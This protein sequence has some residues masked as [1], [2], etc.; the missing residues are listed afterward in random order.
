M[1]ATIK[2][3]AVKTGLGVGTISKYLNGGSVKEKNRIIIES[4]IKELNYTVNEFARGLKTNKTRT[5]GILVPEFENLF[6]MSIVSVIEE[7]LQKEGYGILA[8]D[9][10]NDVNLEEQA[11]E[12]LLKKHVSGIINIPV[13]TSGK[14]L[15]AAQEQ[16]IPFVIIDR[17]LRGIDCNTVIIDNVK[18]SYDVTELL[19]NSGHKKIGILCGPKSVFT[20]QRR[21][22]GYRRALMKHSI[23]PDKKLI[24][25]GN[26]KIEGGYQAAKRL[27]TANE[28]MTAL[29]V[30]D[31]ENTL[32]AM[33]ALNECGIKVPDDLSVV[34]FDNLDLTKVLRPRL[35][36]VSQPIE[37]IG[38]YA[39][40][41]FLEGVT[42]KEKIIPHTI[43]LDANIIYGESVKTIKV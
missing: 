9:C 11:V 21:V 36:I 28:D 14:H 13:S 20:A 23:K 7:C 2:D 38:R 31:Y 6:Y 25:Y 18:A 43:I 33:I 3:I 27:I 42:T 15:H 1:S 30:T 26:D 10:K 8:C 17:K 24:E 4:A 34:G 29:F 32:G 41:L 37:E 40:E 39:A 16:G 5:A 12:F 19:I 35:T 22:A